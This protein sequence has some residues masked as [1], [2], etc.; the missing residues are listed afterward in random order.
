MTLR[1]ALF[2][3]DGTLIQTHIDFPAM[4]EAMTQMARAAEVPS[5]SYEGKDILGIVN[6]AADALAA[7]GGEGAAF[8][9]AAFA[10]L[11]AWEVSGCAHPLLLPGTQTLLSGLTARGI[12]IGV[13]TRNCRRVSVDLLAQFALPYDVLLTRDD[14]T[15]AKPHPQHLWDALR[16]LDCS[17]DAAVMV[18]DHWMDIQA[19]RRAHVARATMP[20][21]GSLRVR[22]MLWCRIC[23]TQKDC[24]TDAHGLHCQL[25]H[26]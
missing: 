4:A 9:R 23:R 3:L 25:E 11:E 19:G 13:V 8:R 12:K 10:Q 20:R 21:I 7:R 26:T 5:S 24:L 14:V 2:D 17:P 22:R 1:A 16:A 15:Q 6:G 18:G